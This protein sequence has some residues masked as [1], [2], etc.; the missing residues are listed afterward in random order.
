MKCLTTAIA[1]GAMFVMIIT[2]SYSC[3]KL[4]TTKFPSDWLPGI[5]LLALGGELQDW[6]GSSLPLKMSF[7]VYLVVNHISSSIITSCGYAKSICDNIISNADKKFN[8]NAIFTSNLAVSI[9]VSIG[10]SCLAAISTKYLN[11]LALSVC[12]VSIDK[13]TNKQTID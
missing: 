11:G 12:F 8:K 10:S 3:V 1:T 9:A 4:I 6:D 13:Q 5:H 7:I 2:V